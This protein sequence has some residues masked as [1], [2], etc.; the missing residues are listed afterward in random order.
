M[1]TG[2]PLPGNP[3]H[4]L[5]AASG[6]AQAEFPPAKYTKPHLCHGPNTT[7]EN[8]GPSTKSAT[9]PISAVPSFQNIWG[10][11]LSLPLFPTDPGAQENKCSH[12]LG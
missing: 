1:S 2:S 10:S 8:L 4:W 6:A 5:P 7:R 9:L 11:G 3:L 12:L